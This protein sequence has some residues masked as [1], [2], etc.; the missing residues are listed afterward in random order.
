MVDGLSVTER[1]EVIELILGL[2]VRDADM[3]Q[4]HPHLKELY[5]Q[6]AE[7]CKLVKDSTDKYAEELEK[8]RTFEKLKQDY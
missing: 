5:K 4:K 2:P 6:H 8:L 3:E 7:R 1:L